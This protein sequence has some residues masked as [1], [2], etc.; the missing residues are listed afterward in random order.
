MKQTHIRY[1]LQLLIEASPLHKSDIARWLM[2]I[3]R[4]PRIDDVVHVK[5]LR[6]AHQICGAVEMRQGRK[7]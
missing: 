7:V 5:P 4:H 1:P 6:R 3:P 2:Q